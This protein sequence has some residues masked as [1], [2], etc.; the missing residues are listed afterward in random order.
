M[1]KM[2]AG[3]FLDWFAPGLVLLLLMA[4]LSKARAASAAELLEK[5]IYTEETRGDLKAATEIYRQ[6]AEDARADR[7]LVAQSQLRLGL[8]QLKL[9]NRPQAIS[10]L[11]KL[12]QEFPDQEKLLAIVENHMPQVLDE[13]VGQIER[14]Y[15]Q[16]VDRGELIETAIRAIVGKLDSRGSL[17]RADALEFYGAREMSQLNDHLEQKLA[18]I[19]AMLKAES[20]EVIVQTPLAGSP[21]LDAGLKA[22]DRIVTIDGT[23]LPEEKAIEAAVKLL[24][25]PVGTDVTVGI[26][27]AGSDQLQEIKL[28]RNTIRLPSV[29]GDRRKPD[30]NWEFMLDEAQK[31]G[32]LRLTQVGKQSAEEMYAALTELKSRDMKGL[33]LDLR[34]NPGGLLDGAVEVADFFVETGR[35]LTV[36]GRQGETVYEAKAEDTFSGFPVALVVNRKTASSGEIIAACLQDRQRAVV[37]GERTFGEGIVRGFFRLKNNVGAMKIPVASYYRPSGKAMNRYPDAKDSDDWGVT[38]DPGYEVSFT[39]EEL[40]AYEKDRAARDTLSSEA[41]PKLGFE[42]RQLKKALDYMTAQLSRGKK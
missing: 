34:N 5:G 27:H 16:E 17:L 15:L 32:Y 1:K 33:I 8:C 9:G 19:G 37:I 23:E 10:A 18:G 24:R 41:T 29:L 39:D 7:S 12:M 25:G 22:G 26:K 35:I 13:I 36:K 3:G 40:K 11:D 4:P 30:H 14:N 42:D 31:I 20:G 28:T 38:P 6:I 2:V 21:A